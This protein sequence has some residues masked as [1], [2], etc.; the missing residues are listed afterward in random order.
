M[1]VGH[2]GDPDTEEADVRGLLYKGSWPDSKK[3]SSN[4]TNMFSM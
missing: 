3:P 1:S 4:K 2:G